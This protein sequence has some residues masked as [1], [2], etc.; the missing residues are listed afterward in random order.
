MGILQLKNLSLTLG[1]KNILNGLNAE[2]WEGHV[3]AIV[4]PNGAGKSTLA[5]TL[6][7][8]S[9]YRGATGSII[10]DGQDITGLSIDE[11]ARLGISMGWQEPA[12]YEGLT[13]RDFIK[14]GNRSMTNDE[15]GK[16]LEKMGLNPAEYLN[17]AIDKTLSGGER[18]R[19]EMAS[20]LAMKPKLVI[21]DEPDSGIDV[22]A[23]NHIFEAISILKNN[24]STIIM[25]THSHTVLSQA[26]HAFLMCNGVILDKGP[27][28]K[29]VN[30]FQN[31]CM[32]CSHK[33]MPAEEEEMNKP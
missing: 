15:A 7:G 28:D 1:D 24:G 5:S 26:E 2:F 32:P 10:F 25:I 21:L 6:M 3:H 14:A 13:V 4:G 27:A 22:E 16:M 18:K 19:I 17:R 8:L 30:Y 23:L 20:L 29:V 9:G 11:R 33:N 12:R 31:T